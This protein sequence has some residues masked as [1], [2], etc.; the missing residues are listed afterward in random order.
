[1][2]ADNYPFEQL[3]V[4]IELQIAEKDLQASVILIGIFELLCERMLKRVQ[5]RETLQFDQLRQQIAITISH[6][7]EIDRDEHRSFG[8]ARNIPL[9]RHRRVGL[10]QVILVAQQLL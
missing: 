1:M 9:W 2:I 8:L 7:S 5:R 6:Q 3:T 10:A 4:G